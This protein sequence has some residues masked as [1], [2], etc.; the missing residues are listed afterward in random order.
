MFNAPSHAEA[1]CLVQRPVPGCINRYRTELLSFVYNLYYDALHVL[2][3][4][5]C[6]SVPDMK[7]DQEL[8]VAFTTKPVL[9]HVIR[10]C[11]HSLVT[12]S[13][14]V[15]CSYKAENCGFYE[16]ERDNNY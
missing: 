8:V 14:H 5:S 4:D 13:C 1:A 16:P 6:T 9:I 15:R 2:P 3:S 7:Q 10:A 12:F 11:G